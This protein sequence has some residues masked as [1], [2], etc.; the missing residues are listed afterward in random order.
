MEFET[1]EQ[2]AKRENVTVRTVQLWAKEG[3]IEGAK[4]VGRDWLIPVNAS[5]SKKPADSSDTSVF[6]P[7]TAKFTKDQSFSEFISTIKSDEERI[8]ATGEYYYFTGQ[9]DKAVESVYDLLTSPNPAIYFSAS[10]IYFY[11]KLA[12]GMTHLANLSMKNIQERLSKILSEKTDD[13]TTAIAVFACSLLSAQLHIPDKK[14]PPLEDYIKYLDGG[15]KYFALNIIA[16]NAFLKKDYSRAYGLA[17]ATL[18]MMPEKYCVTGIHLH[19][20]DAICLMQLTNPK[21][22]KRHFASA[23]EFAE[24][25][26]LFAPFVEYHLLLQGVLEAQLKKTHPKEYQ[27]INELSARFGAGWRGVHNEVLNKTVA[28][29]LT[30]TE[31]IIAM[32]Y[33]HNWRIKEIAA[34]IGLSERTIKNYLQIIY[35]KLGINGKKDLEQFMIN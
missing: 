3:K 29:N 34:H 25:E 23:F 14:I 20:L 28:D 26:R 16:Y 24:K 22:A 21:D 18:I 27:F 4:K 15:V 9:C 17:E 35:Q 5:V 1:A 10:I 12:L 6:L 32:L 2:V 8:L 19:T 33:H 7:F 11:S 30:T 31:F 13:R